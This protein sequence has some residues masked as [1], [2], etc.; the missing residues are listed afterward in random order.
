MVRDELLNGTFMLRFETDLDLFLAGFDS[1]CRR[2]V[3][4]RF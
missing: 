3:S 1:L 2:N 4:L